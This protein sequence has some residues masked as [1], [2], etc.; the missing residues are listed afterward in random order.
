MHGGGGAVGPGVVRDEGERDFG[1]FAGGGGGR[2]V[3]RAA[4]ASGLHGGAFVAEDH[5][6]VEEIFVEGLGEA[7]GGFRVSSDESDIG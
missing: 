3:E 6:A 2:E 7:V 1:G 4:G 5:D